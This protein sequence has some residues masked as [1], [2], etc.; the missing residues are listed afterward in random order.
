MVSKNRLLVYCP[1][2]KGKRM[3]EYVR[4]PNS[5]KKI[6]CPI[7]KRTFK[8]MGYKISTNL[9]Q[10]CDDF[11]AVCVDGQHDVYKFLT[12]GTRALGKDKVYIQDFFGGIWT[13]QGLIYVA[14]MN[15]NGEFELL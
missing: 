14:K 8:E 2:W 10:L 1:L 3:N 9:E 4:L 13:K 15:D 7:D 11:V 12:D 5:I 6:T